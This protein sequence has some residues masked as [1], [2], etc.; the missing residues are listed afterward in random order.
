MNRRAPPSN[1]Q[2]PRASGQVRV[3]GG[4]WRGSK[5]PVVG[6][7]GLR[8][9]SD[10]V[11]ETL[12]NWL[13][14]DVAGARALD[15][16]AGS[17]ALGVEAASRGA[18]SVD[19][20]EA[21]PVAAAALRDSVARLIRGSGDAGAGAAGDRSSEQRVSVHATA[22]AAFLAD[23]AAR[24]KTFDLVFIDPPFAAGL[25]NATLA[26]L[27]PCLAPRASVYVESPPGTAVTLPAG[28]RLHRELA[29][30][31]ARAVLYRVDA[32]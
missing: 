16:F 13:Q 4:R 27:V 23:A 28:W 19:L 22:A 20:V 6:V 1:P 9:T 30:R 31:D 24:G 32:G 15:L 10:R 25:W 8:P 21:S 26:A 11:R 18:A 5:L 29:T 7:D 3:I 12:F 2:A 14:H 17:G